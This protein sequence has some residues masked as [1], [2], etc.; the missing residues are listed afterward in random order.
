MSLVVL[1]SAVRR[2]TDGT[3][4]NAPAGL[5]ALLSEQIPARREVHAS[6]GNDD[7][8]GDACF[9]EIQDAFLISISFPLSNTISICPPDYDY[10]P[11]RGGRAC[12]RRF[13]SFC[14]I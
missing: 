8:S 14:R 13:Q 9:C 10:A 7:L 3:G 4:E 12:R 6:P 2:I 1:S 5:S 11:R